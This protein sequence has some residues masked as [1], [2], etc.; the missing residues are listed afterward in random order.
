MVCSGKSS[1]ILY[2][3]CSVHCQGKKICLVTDCHF[4]TNVA[5]YQ[6]YS[7]SRCPY[8][9]WARDLPTVA[10][11][12]I[13]AELVN[14]W[15]FLM[16][17]LAIKRLIN[18]DLG[19]EQCGPT[20]VGV[21]LKGKRQ[22]HTC[23]IPEMIICFWSFE[24]PCS[25]LTPKQLVITRWHVGA[26]WALWPEHSDFLTPYLLESNASPDSELYCS[27]K[28]QQLPSEWAEVTLS[29]DPWITGPGSLFH[30]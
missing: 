22:K 23:H 26:Y 11:W 25:D 18:L 19:S 4:R 21:S 1:F 30:P 3:V 6:W 10:L 16:L 5:T 8:N 27:L 28:K 14:G 17:D 24:H 9:I 2:L 29:G 15:P 20:A 7:K 12:R 13:S